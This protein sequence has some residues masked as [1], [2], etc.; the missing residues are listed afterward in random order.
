MKTQP[1]DPSLTSDLCCSETTTL[2]SVIV[3]T[4]GAGQQ[5]TAYLVIFGADLSQV[6]LIF[7]K[8]I[9]KEWSTL[10]LEP[11]AD[12]VLTVKDKSLGRQSF[13]TRSDFA[14]LTPFYLSKVRQVVVCKTDYYNY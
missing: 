1:P 3:I 6:F 13:L 8:G 7:Y 5:F 2:V 12:Q 14:D 10:Q 9:L 4:E 11:A